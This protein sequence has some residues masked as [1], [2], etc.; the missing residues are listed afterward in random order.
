M[1]LDAG[2]RV[3]PYEVIQ[4]RGHRARPAPDR[5]R[6]EAGRPLILALLDTSLDELFAL[7]RRRTSLAWAAVVCAVE[8]SS[9]GKFL[10]MVVN[11]LLEIA[12]CRPELGIGRQMFWD[13]GGEARAEDA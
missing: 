3:G 5:R 6:S 7:E 2:T 13:E 12:E 11:G 9:C 10:A 4:I 8:S 1:L